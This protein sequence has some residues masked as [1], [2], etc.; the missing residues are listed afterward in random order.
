MVAAAIG[1]APA[2]NPTLRGVRALYCGPGARRTGRADQVVVHLASPLPPPGHGSLAMAFVIYLV[3]DRL[4]LAI[5]VAVAA[6][7]LLV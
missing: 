2:L 4:A 6:L 7:F 1:D 3:T 5:V